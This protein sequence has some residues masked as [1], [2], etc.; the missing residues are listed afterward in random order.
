MDAQREIVLQTGNDYLVPAAGL[1]QILATYQ[2]KK[3]FIEQVLKEGIDYG[4]TPGTSEKPSLKKPGAEKMATFFGLAPVFEDVA[5]IEDWTGGDHG[6][7]PFFYY[8]QKCKLYRGERMV[9]S[10]D[11]SC[12]SWEK[13]YRYR[14]VSELEIP[15]TADKATLRT[16]GGKTYE[17]AFAIEKAET[18]G[19][20]GKPAAYWKRWQDAIASGAA[21]PI[22]RKARNGRELDAFEMDSTLYAVK[23]P[24]VAEQTNTILKMAQKRALVAAV[25]IVTNASDYF[26][27]DLDDLGDFVTGEI[28]EGALKDGA[29]E[30]SRE[31][32]K[33]EQPPEGE[34]ASAEATANPDPVPDAMWQNWQAL[35]ARADAAKVQHGNPDRAKITRSEMSAGYNELLAKVKTCEK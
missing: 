16:Q 4:S 27:Q 2:L 10:A 33:T 30:Q 23:N 3:E 25:L 34:A 7:E 32:P 14:W 18:G 26:T 31:Q 15:A 9:G 24:D 28:V 13:K 19:Q 11:G 21:K 17:F 12:N 6:G 20:Y 22:K 1:Q 29:G 5:T 8:R 35:C